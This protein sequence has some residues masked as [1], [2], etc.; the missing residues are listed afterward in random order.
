MLWVESGRFLNLQTPLGENKFLLRAFRGHEG[1]SQ[2]F[3]FHLDLLSEDPA[4]NFDELVGQNVS[5]AVRLAETSQE[6]Y[7]NG[8]ISRF[9]QLPGEERFTRYEAE[10]VPWLWFLTRTTDCRIFQ[11]KSVPEIAEEIFKYFGFT[12]YESQ[13]RGHYA[14]WEYCVQ[15]RETAFNFLSRLFEQEG[16]YYFF[17]HENGKHT[18][19]LADNPS[20]HKPCPGQSRVM[21]ERNVGAV[22]REEDVVFSWKQ[23]QQFRSGKITLT[24]YNFET[25]TTSLE[26]GI[27]S[28]INQA[29]NHRFEMYDYPGEYGN[30]DKGDALAKLRIE[31][32]EA[33]HTVFSGESDCRSFA[34]G[35][36]FELFGHERRDQNATYLLTSVTHS[37][38]E[39]GFYSGAGSATSATYRNQ[40]TA[41]LS[42]VQF[43][44]PRVTPKPVIHGSQT[45][46]VAGP[47]G[48]EVY[49]DKYGRIKVQ[50]HWDRVGQRNEN[51]SCWV[52][53]AQPWAGK[54][55]GGIVIPRIGQE[56]V[57][58]FLEGDPDRPLVTGTV[59]N[60]VQTPPYS[61]PDK[62][63][64]SGFKSCS[65]K[66]GGNSNEIRLDDTKGSELFYVHAAR[67]LDML[68]DNNRR[69]TIGR[70]S[71]HLI[72]GIQF[73]KT[74][75]DRNIHVVGDFK[76]KVDGN[77]SLSAGADLD[78][79]VRGKWA[80]SAGNEIH[81]KGGMKVVIEA[82]TQL[83][84]KVG[85][86]FVDINPGGVFIKGTMVMINSGGSAGS[87]SGAS[88]TAPDAPEEV[89]PGE[90][91]QVAPPPPPP[92]PPRPAQY[93]PAATAL[94]QA[95]Q[96][97]APFCEV[98]ARE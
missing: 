10:V 71:H 48:E 30:R 34:S 5:F 58:S 19:I 15:Y 9:S 44:P 67:D 33:A 23:D 88:P 96:S 27:A 7:F 28:H 60:A 20:V 29:G 57:V 90:A 55:W 78:E 92:R 38:Q 72:K 93:S 87:G 35:Y 1:L 47:S 21:F 41:I 43:R 24:D 91:T 53:V 73:E 12:D 13:L 97:G 89:K 64:V 31:A 54:G 65:S 46:V 62:Q 94:R 61:L 69:E 45:A 86:N 56:V 77:M 70:D 39:G 49:T 11:N 6:R 26:A 82:G 32:E 63:V 51:S 40:F 83:T 52:R 22:A 80:C 95:A 16:I 3:H 66:G 14:K 59:Y 84:I 50:F 81:L 8:Y 75:G 17:R 74:Q 79:G 2:L 37:A 42:S 76:Q 98:C 68:V 85:G 18:L 4:V 25:P 36:K